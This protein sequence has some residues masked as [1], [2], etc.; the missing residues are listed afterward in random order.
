[1]ARMVAPTVLLMQSS[2]G[3]ILKRLATE[4]VLINR[5]GP[6]TFAFKRSRQVPTRFHCKNG[7]TLLVL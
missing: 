1:M 3:A 5:Q 6:I 7:V 4:F 2:P